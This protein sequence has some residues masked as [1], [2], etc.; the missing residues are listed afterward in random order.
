MYTD[1]FLSV[2]L[3]AYNEEENI[4]KTIISTVAYLDITFNKYEVIV[5]NNGSVDGTKEI[6]KISL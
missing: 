6:I 1:I 5:V 2:V 3:P 4:K